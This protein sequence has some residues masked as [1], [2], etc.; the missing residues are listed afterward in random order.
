MKAVWLTTRKAR[1]RKKHYGMSW[2]EPIL[3]DSGE[4]ARRANGRV[5]MRVFR[6]SCHT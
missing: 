1:G 6:E 5:K 3:D 2:Q 4:P